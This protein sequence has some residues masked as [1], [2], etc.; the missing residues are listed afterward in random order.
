MCVCVV[1]TLGVCACVLCVYVGCCGRTCGVVNFG[2][3]DGCS[4]FCLVAW[5]SRVLCVCVLCVC[6]RVNFEMCEEF[7]ERRMVFVLVRGRV[8]ERAGSAC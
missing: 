5:L 1:C 8:L 2:M 3:G 7:R 6:A 4:V